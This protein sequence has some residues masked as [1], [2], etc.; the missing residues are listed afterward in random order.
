MRHNESLI[1]RSCVMWFRLCYPDSVI[2]AIPNGGNRSAVTGAMLKAEGVLAGVPDLFIMAARGDVHGLFV[3]V[4]TAKGVVQQSQIDFADKA[5]KAGYS[6]AVV[7][8]FDDFREIVTEYMG[9][10]T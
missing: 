6:V 7:R 2:F 10:S 9:K 1:Q 4:K 8:S 5:H 3:E